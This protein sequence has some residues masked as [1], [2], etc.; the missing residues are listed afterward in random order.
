MNEVFLFSNQN[1]QQMKIIAARRSKMSFSSLGIN[2]LHQ[3]NPWVAA[4]WSAALPG[5]GHIHL[6]LYV[7]GIILMAGEILFNIFGNINLAIYYTFTLQFELLH[8]VANYH[9]ALLYCAIYVYSIFDSYRLGIELNSQHWLEAKQSYRDIKTNIVQS[10]DINFLDLRQPWVAVAWSILFSGLGHLYNNKMISGFILIG[11]QVLI[12]TYSGLTYA[13]I[14][15]LTA[16]F[17]LIPEVIDYQWLLFFPSIYFFS[18]YDAYSITVNNNKLF[19]EEQLYFFQ[20]K[21]GNNKLKPLQK[22]V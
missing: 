9:W 4:W 18:I 12:A 8:E 1:Y 17:E 11:W 16:R 5:F 22:R 2:H 20:E 15:T 19:K 10:I 21:Y 3:N 14:Y 6:G 7:K 13:L